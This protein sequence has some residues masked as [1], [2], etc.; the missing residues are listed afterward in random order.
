MNICPGRWNTFGRLCLAFWWRHIPK[1]LSLANRFSEMN[2]N[3]RDC[4]V[5]HVWYWIFIRVITYISDKRFNLIFRLRAL[6]KSIK[7][8]NKFI[9]YVKKFSLK[10]EGRGTLNFFILQ[11]GNYSKYFKIFILYIHF[12]ALFISFLKIIKVS[13]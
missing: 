4:C 9:Y 10:S 11:C 5:S 12:K 8:T 1:V 2:L 13:I 3:S 6:R 7:S